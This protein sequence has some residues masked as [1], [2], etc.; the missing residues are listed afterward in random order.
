MKI[1]KEGYKYYLT[2]GMMERGGMVIDHV[3]IGPLRFRIHARLW[4]PFFQLS[5]GLR[6]HPSHGFQIGSY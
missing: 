3:G 6:G 2:T 4:R 5:Y 1:V